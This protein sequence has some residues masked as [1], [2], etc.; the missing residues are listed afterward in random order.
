MDQVFQSVAFNV[1]DLTS[2]LFYFILS[3]PEDIF[4]IAVR[5]RGSRVGGREKERE[6]ETS[7]PRYVP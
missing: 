6:G 7:K 5:E 2:F 3:S 1:C 4:F